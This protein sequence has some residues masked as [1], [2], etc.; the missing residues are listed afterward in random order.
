MDPV[1]SVMLLPPHTKQIADLFFVGSYWV[2][3]RRFL[4]IN[5]GP[6]PLLRTLDVSVVQTIN[7]DDTDAVTP[8]PHPFFGSAIGLKEFRLRSG[9]PPLLNHFIF[10]NLTLFELSVTSEESFSGLELLDFLEASP[11]LRA[12]CINVAADISLEGVS[13]ERVVVLYHVESFCL[14]AT[15]GSAG[16]ELATNISCPS[17][18]RTSLTHTRE[19]RHYP[20]GPIEEFPAPSLLYAIIRQYTRSSI[21]EIT[22]ETKTDSYYLIACSLTFRSADTTIIRLCFEVTEDN[23]DPGTLGWT[24]T[25]MYWNAFLRASRTIQDTLLVADVKRF[26]MQG[27]L[28]LDEEWITYIVGD[29]EDLFKS[30]G[31]LKELTICNCDMRPHPFVRFAKLC[32]VEAV[33][34]PIKALTIW[35]PSNICNVEFVE[36]LV[37]LAK[38]QHELG[39]PFEHVTVHMHNPPA[40]MEEML[41]LW[42]GTVD[43]RGLL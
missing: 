13:Q 2:D 25:Q 20:E 36:D 30:L 3:I 17:V 7:P 26:Q 22:L 31:P 28:D 8:P 23:E 11:T 27:P 37:G 24:F 1:G 33:Y 9:T 18:K 15:D 38:A 42:V 34:P 16:Y 5:P 19:K 39:V 6:L 21:E 4:E 32:G 41:R 43:C 29:F 14:A 12:V 40:E 35:H 10:P